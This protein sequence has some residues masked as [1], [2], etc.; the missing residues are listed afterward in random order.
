VVQDPLGQRCPFIGAG[1][2]RGAMIMAGIKG[3]TSGGVNGD[4]ST[5]KLQFNGGGVTAAV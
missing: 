2:G 3:E 4:L 5:L 1:G